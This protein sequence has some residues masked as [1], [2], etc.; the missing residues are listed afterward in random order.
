MSDLCLR[1][2]EVHAA[3]GVAVVA[4]FGEHD[5]WTVPSLEKL[6]ADLN[7]SDGSSGHVVVDLTETQFIDSSVI[8]A[9]LTFANRRK[10]RVSAVTAPGTPPARV[11]ELLML[12]K[13]FPTYASTEEA[14]NGLSLAG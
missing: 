3:S 10:G 8:Q 4:L 6:L 7:G 13:V 1:R 2:I 9:L 14:I 12:P 5:L 11:F